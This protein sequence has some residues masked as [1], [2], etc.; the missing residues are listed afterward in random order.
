MHLLFRQ[1]ERV[2]SKCTE[3]RRAFELF[4]TVPLIVTSSLPYA[5]FDN[6]TSSK[7]RSVALIAVKAA[8]AYSTVCFEATARSFS[9]SSALFRLDVTATVRINPKMAISTKMN[10]L[11]AGRLDG[12]DNDAAKNEN[13]QKKVHR[14]YFQLESAILNV[15]P[16]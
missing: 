16:A 10:T 13:D 3:E 12:Q 4:V 1:S 8:N 5:A 14:F 6:V 15:L 9:D 11:K 7:S 2:M